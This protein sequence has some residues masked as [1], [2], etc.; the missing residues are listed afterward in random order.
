[1]F[2]EYVP[3]ILIIDYLTIVIS[4]VSDMC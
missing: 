2:V 4:N 1:M 3:S